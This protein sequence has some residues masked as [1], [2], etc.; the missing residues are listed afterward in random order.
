MAYFKHGY[1]KVFSYDEVKTHFG[2]FEACNNDGPGLDPTKCIFFVQKDDDIDVL[3]IVHDR[4]EIYTL[5]CGK[6]GIWDKIS[7]IIPE[8]SIL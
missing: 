6:V 7:I 1:F 2:I 5:R 4:R 3:R 8:T